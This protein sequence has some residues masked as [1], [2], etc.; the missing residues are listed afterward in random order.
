MDN[1][2]GNDT[3]TDTSLELSLAVF[4]AIL[5]IYAC[6]L[7]YSWYDIHFAS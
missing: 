1:N 4:C 7:G 5:V 6:F 2:G 3:K